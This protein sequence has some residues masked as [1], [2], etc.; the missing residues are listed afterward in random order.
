MTEPILPPPGAPALEACWVYPDTNVLM[1]FRPLD[2]MPLSKMLNVPG[3]LTIV[4]TTTLLDELEQQ[5]VKNS[6]PD[7]R[8]RAQRVIGRLRR[9]KQDGDTRLSNGALVL[10]KTRRHGMDLRALGLDETIRDDHFL[11]EIL[12]ARETTVGRHVLLTADFSAE[13]R[14]EARGI[15]VASPLEE[16]RLAVP[17]ATEKELR[18]AR[19]ELQEIQARLPVLSLR[20]A[21]GKEHMERTIRLPAATTEGDLQR[22]VEKERRSLVMSLREPTYAD[23]FGLD[24]SSLDH[25][26][27]TNEQIRSY[28]KS[29]D[30]YLSAL[31]EHFRKWRTADQELFARTLEIPLELQNDGGGTASTVRISVTGPPGINFAVAA[32]QGHRGPKEPTQPRGLTDLRGWVDSPLVNPDLFQPKPAPN[33]RGPW[34]TNDE[35]PSVSFLIERALHKNTYDLGSFFLIYPTIDAIRPVT[36]EASVM[37]AETTDWVKTKLNVRTI[38]QPDV[39][40]TDD[41]GLER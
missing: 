7:L 26:R 2:E 21:G 14:A 19:K 28:N 37:S 40:P 17:D 11:A 30:D 20:F 10:F 27:P 22:I 24:L 25:T 15:E 32:P 4:L 6:N 12:C 13:I 41:L 5:K 34:A 23:A 39:T 35:L 18:K 31:V 1:H 9:W 8:E 3:P 38:V 16:D 29:V 33:V 36:L